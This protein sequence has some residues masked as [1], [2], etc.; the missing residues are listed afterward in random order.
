MVYATVKGDGRGWGLLWSS[1][2]TRWGAGEGCGWSR[3]VRGG[4]AGEG[5][6][7][8]SEAEVGRGC[9]PDATA[10]AIYP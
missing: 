2:G 4:G 9:Q 10:G 8:S 3:R 7:M 5:V 1:E 6:W